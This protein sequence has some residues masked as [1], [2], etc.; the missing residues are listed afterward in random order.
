MAVKNNIVS[1]RWQIYIQV[2]QNDEIILQYLTSGNMN[3]VII[4]ANN[5]AAEGKRIHIFSEP[6]PD[7]AW[8]S[9]GH[10]TQILAQEQQ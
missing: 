4:L 8:K 7:E 9:P 5:L 1:T 10:I 6:Q 3:D 2:K